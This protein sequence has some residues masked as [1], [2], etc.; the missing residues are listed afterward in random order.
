MIRRGANEVGG[1]SEGQRATGDGVAGYTTGRGSGAADR[2]DIRVFEEGLAAK[3][4][5]YSEYSPRDRQEAEGTRL[6]EIAKRHGKYI[7]PKV[8]ERLGTKYPHRTGES[9]V[10]INEERGRVYKVKNPYAKAAIKGGDAEDAIYEHLLHNRLFP[11]AAYRLEGISEHLGDVR[12]VLSQ[13]YVN[14]NRSVPPARIEAE[15]AARGLHPDGRYS[16]GNDLVSVTD[17]EGD[18]VLLSDDG[19]VYFID[20]IIKP[21]RPARE[22][23]DALEGQL[24]SMWT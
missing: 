20:P 3:P 15:L 14:A 10:Y 1:V 24:M 13:A 19:R 16:Y 22:V 4:D 6:I 12:L 17:V 7:E 9:V 2:S 18:N 11:E 5:D 21:K 23:L 8:L